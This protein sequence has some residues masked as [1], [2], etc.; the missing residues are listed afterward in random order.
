MLLPN[1]NCSFGDTGIL[2][3]ND[4]S[5]CVIQ[6]S[7]F[8]TDVCNQPTRLNDEKGSA[9]FSLEFVYYREGKSKL[10][11]PFPISAAIFFFLVVRV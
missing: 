1:A 9:N 5:V 2:Y 11:F 10:C 4:N 8:T 6:H 7:I 3:V